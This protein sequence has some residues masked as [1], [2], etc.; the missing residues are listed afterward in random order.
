MLTLNNLIDGRIAAPARGAYL[1]VFEP[2]T[3]AVFAKCPDSD[4]TDV[5]AAIAAATRAAPAWGAT[6]ADERSRLLMRLADLVE[7]DLEQLAELESRDS[8][9]PV[10]LARNL[11]I[12]RAI[13]NLRFFAAAITQWPSEAHPMENAALNYTLRQPLGV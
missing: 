12:P 8:G 13:A 11:D 6:P 7:R 5:D 10:K 9:K 4:A 3:G 2:A 1:N